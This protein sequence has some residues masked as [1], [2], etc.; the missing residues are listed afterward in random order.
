MLSVSLLDQVYRLQVSLGILWGHFSVLGSRVLF[1]SVL[2]RALGCFGVNL[3]GFWELWGSLWM[4]FSRFV[5]FCWIALTL[6]PKSAFVRFGRSR[7]VPFCQLL[8]V[9]IEGVNL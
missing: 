3:G 8:Q 1:L 2:G 4:T 6:Q 5:G 9:L 7:A